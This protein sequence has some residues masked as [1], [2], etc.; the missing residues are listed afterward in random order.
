MVVIPIN[1][2]VVNV[3]LYISGQPISIARKDFS[4]EALHYL[5]LYDLKSFEQVQAETKI[6]L[7]VG[8]S[9]TSEILGQLFEHQTLDL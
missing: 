5:C 6:A 2:K 8:F 9:N 3:F 1:Q 4:S 7:M